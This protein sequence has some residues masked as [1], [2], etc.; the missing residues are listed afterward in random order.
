MSN[1]LDKKTWTPQGRPG[2]RDREPHAEPP[3]DKP[4]GGDKK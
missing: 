4:Q 3:K 1:D 2:D